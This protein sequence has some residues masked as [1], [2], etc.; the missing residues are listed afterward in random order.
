MR[1]DSLERVVRRRFGRGEAARMWRSRLWCCVGDGLCRWRE[2][3]VGGLREFAVRGWRLAR[4]SIRPFRSS[5]QRGEALLLGRHRRAVDAFSRRPD[6][7]ERRG[8]QWGRKRKTYTTLS[9]SDYQDKA[10][11]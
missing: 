9:V 10:V 1:I 8:N 6:C 11:S 7:V 4:G 5:G 2:V 3:E